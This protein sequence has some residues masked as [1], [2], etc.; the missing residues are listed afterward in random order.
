M[1]EKQEQ[2]IDKDLPALKDL[3]SKTILIDLS[4]EE[5]KYSIT[6]NWKIYEIRGA[7]LQ[8]YEDIV[9]YSSSSQRLDAVYTSVINKEESLKAKIKELIMYTVEK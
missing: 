8:A 2:E 1:T 5:L 4:A 9:N 7:L 6:G 3:P